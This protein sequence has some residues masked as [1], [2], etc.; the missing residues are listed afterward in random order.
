MN[1][2][3]EEKVHS[4]V[5]TNII[6]AINKYISSKNLMAMFNEIN[7]DDTFFIRAGDIN[8]LSKYLLYKPVKSKNIKNTLY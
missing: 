7:S 1:R 8:Q 2:L 4:S 6:A 3:K 5:I